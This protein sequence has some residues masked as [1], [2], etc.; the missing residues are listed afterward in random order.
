MD[1]G[2]SGYAA[3]EVYREVG[4]WPTIHHDSSNSGVL[5][6]GIASPREFRLKWSALEN[7][8]VLSSPVVGDDGRVYVTATEE[9]FEAIPEW[10][11][12][13]MQ[14]R[15]YAL[16]AE[17]GRIIWGARGIRSGGMAGAP[18]LIRNQAGELSIIV[19]A[20][21]WL[22]AYDADGSIR[23]R[24]PMGTYEVGIS[25]HLSPDGRAIVVGTNEGSVHLKDPGSGANLLSPYNSDDFVNTNTPAVAS[26]GIVILVGTYI[27]DS[28]DGVAW[29]VKPD[30]ASGTWETMWVYEELEG[31]SQASPT[32][33]HEGDRVYIADGHANLVAITV[34]S[35]EEI[36]RY[37][38]AYL[39]GDDYLSYA[40]VAATP[41]GLVGLG[42]VHPSY[43]LDPRLIDFIDYYG[44]L[45]GY[46]LLGPFG[47]FIENL[48]WESLPKFMVVLEDRGDC[49]EV[50]YLRDWKV[51]SGVSYSAGSGLFY[52]T[53]MQRDPLSGRM[54]DIV[55]GLDHE[56]GEAYTQPLENP[57]LNN[58]TLASGAL[59]VPVFWGGL[60]DIPLMTSQ[61]YGLHYYEDAQGS[62]L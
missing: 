41:E 28:E 45:I 27:H 24:S 36:W 1:A 20:A 19:S 18:L 22:M 46:I 34:G 52:F 33:N 40:S 4:E 10:E 9:N 49:A 38:F 25:A 37:D 59:I 43:N 56:T 6:H 50:K 51:T 35:G 3:A 54:V 44:T 17:T 61:G 11:S 62:D 47:V 16:D 57:C 14:S 23:W 26:D 2:A 55:V 58:I 21:G 29:A 42:M 8:S 60:I 39:M 32:I 15:L 13:L 5:P 48:S 12:G 30:I 31:E 53:G 7:A